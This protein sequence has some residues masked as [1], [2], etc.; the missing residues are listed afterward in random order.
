M[1]KQPKLKFDHPDALSDIRSEMRRRGFSAFDSYAGV[2]TSVT[3]GSSVADYQTECDAMASLYLR[4]LGVEHAVPEYGPIKLDYE[5]RRQTAAGK[6]LAE[7]LLAS[8]YIQRDLEAK[9]LPVDEPPT[10]GKRSE[11]RKYAEQFGASKG[12]AVSRSGML[13]RRVLQKKPAHPLRPLGEIYIDVG[14]QRGNVWSSHL[15]QFYLGDHDG[16]YLDSIE[17][18]KTE[19]GMLYY[20]SAQPQFNVLRAN[21]FQ[22]PQSEEEIAGLIKLGVMAGITYFD[23]LLDRLELTSGWSDIAP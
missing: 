16:R 23:L 1:S 3:G 20:G 6:E 14:G 18:F 12:F 19:P 8:V 5:Q 10:I 15:M 4:K 13:G 22:H 2:V 17:L 9:R 7:K 11:L 21:R